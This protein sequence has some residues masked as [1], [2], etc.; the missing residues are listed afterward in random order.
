MSD[1]R[2]PAQPAELVEPGPRVPPAGPPP[3][4]PLPPQ[5]GGLKGSLPWGLVRAVRP[6]QWVKNVLVFAAPLAAGRV[7]D[8][9]VLVPTLVAFVLFCLVSGA[10]YLVNDAIDVEE[11]RRHP[12]KR[13]RPIAS[14]LVPRGLAVALAVVLA[15]TALTLA[16]VLTRPE[17]VWVLS[18]YVVLQLAYCVWLKNQPVL[19]LAVVASGFL[20]RAVAGGVAAG[21]A[22][23]QWFLLVASFGSLFMVAGKRYS[24]LVLLGDAAQTRKTLQEYSASY[25]RF[26]WGLS[27]G[28]ACTAYSLWAFE[29]HELRGGVPW[30]TLSIAPF[31]L[32]ILR[33]AV[34]ID[35]GT[36]GAPEE[37]VLHDRV[38]LVLGLVWVV[39]VG[40]GVFGG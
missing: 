32:G 16:A 40:A 20:L 36:A 3:L 29:M 28:V 22:P 18:I 21:L 24:E 13:L 39:T 6:H 25:L 19:D 5:P 15:A 10:V 12:R 2:S 37:I 38:L 1:P 8:A 17:L 33:Y 35:K 7:L 11:D 14:G 4:P 9:D 30:A 27:A 34:D 26:V 23:S 31:V